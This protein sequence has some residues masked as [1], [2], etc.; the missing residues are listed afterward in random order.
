MSL[1]EEI[2][3]FLS[4]ALDPTDIE[5]INVSDQHAGHPEHDDSGETHYIV[6]IA[7][8]YFKDMKPIDQHRM[9]YDTLAPFFH[10][11]LHSVQIETKASESEVE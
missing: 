3:Q 6:R 2:T 11:G 7:S 10:K 9:V 8:P 4:D 1:E 5:V